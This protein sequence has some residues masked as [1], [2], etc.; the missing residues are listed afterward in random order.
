MQQKGFSLTEEYGKLHL[1]QSF[2]FSK[3]V[4]HFNEKYKEP[5]HR[6]PAGESKFIDN[7]REKYEI[8][9]SLMLDKDVAEYLTTWDKTAERRMLEKFGPYG[10]QGHFIGIGGRPCKI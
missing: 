2:D 8:P 5:T 10:T 1:A 4:K 7:A 3:E 6:G 9:M